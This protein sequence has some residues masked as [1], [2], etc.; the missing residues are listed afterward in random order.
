M[1]FILPSFLSSIS[2]IIQ[3][4]PSSFASAINPQ[5][6]TS[7]ISASPGSSTNA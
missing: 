6:F 2:S 4:M 5:V 7:T 1:Y 3:F